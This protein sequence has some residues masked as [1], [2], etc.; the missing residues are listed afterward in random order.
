MTRTHTLLTIAVAA[1]LAGCGQGNNTVT[2]GG[3]EDEA[4]ANASTNAK[5]ELPPSIIATKTYRCADNSVITVDYLSDGKSAN[6]RAEQGAAATLVTAAEAGKPM[7]SADG[8][9]VEGSA[10]AASAKITVPGKSSQSC[11]A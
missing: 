8:Y 11:K 9:S 5:I 10:E 3:P 6:V 1:A 2:A 4:A 7:T